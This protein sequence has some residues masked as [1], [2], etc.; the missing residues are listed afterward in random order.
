MRP[1][2]LEV[3]KFLGLESLS[4]DFDSSFFVLVGPN[5][6]GKSSI[7][8]A[9]FFALFG[10]GIRLERGKR[11]LIH[12]GYPEG[13]LRVKLKFLLGGNEFQVVREYSPRGWGGSFREKGKWRLEGFSFRGAAGE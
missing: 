5:G 4:L 13:P 8:E 3:E 11:E 2:E 10:R 7:L 9:I 12:R 1:L 6:A